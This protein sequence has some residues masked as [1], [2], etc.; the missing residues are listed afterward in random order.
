MPNS[1]EPRLIL[2]VPAWPAVRLAYESWNVS[3]V[4]AEL[5]EKIDRATTPPGIGQPNPATEFKV[6]ALPSNAPIP[7]G[8]DITPEE[9]RRMLVCGI[10]MTG[11]PQAAA[12]LAASVHAAFGAEASIGADLAVSP[13]QDAGPI[14][15]HWCPDEAAYG[16]FGDRAMALRTIEARKAQLTAQGLP[17]HKRVNLVFVD[18]GLP[19]YLLPETPFKGW[20]V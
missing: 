12:A 15:S 19:S 4:E 11:G 14:W 2:A 13:P 9:F 1:N 7:E 10:V 16:L 5:K 8:L 6:L 17:G 18:T 3:E 20:P